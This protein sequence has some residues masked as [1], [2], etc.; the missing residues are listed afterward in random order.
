MPNT[1]GGFA[2]VKLK[3]I[4]TKRFAIL[5]TTAF[6]ALIGLILIGISL[7]KELDLES[8]TNNLNQI[9]NDWQT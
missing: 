9:I 5:C 8:Q 3:G 2:V 7:N 1:N 4:S 6:Y